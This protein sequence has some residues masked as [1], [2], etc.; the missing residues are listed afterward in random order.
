MNSTVVSFGMAMEISMCFGVAAMAA[1]SEMFAT[2]DFLP[3]CSAV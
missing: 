2:T 3:I 1:R